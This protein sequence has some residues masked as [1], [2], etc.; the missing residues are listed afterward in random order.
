M[1]TGGRNLIHI[2]SI[3]PAGT[4]LDKLISGRHYKGNFSNLTAK[5]RIGV[6]VMK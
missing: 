6:Y 5:S 3:N 1:F 4:E 2:K